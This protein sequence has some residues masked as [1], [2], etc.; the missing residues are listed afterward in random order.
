M[1]SMERRVD[2]QGR[3]AIPKSLRLAMGIKAGDELEIIPG[4]NEITLRHKTCCIFCNG[5]EGLIEY[6][7]KYVCKRCIKVLNS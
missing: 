2:A 4:K 7:D 3:I 6:N 5:T 1:A